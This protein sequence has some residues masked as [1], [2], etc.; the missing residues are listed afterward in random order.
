MAHIDFPPHTATSARAPA[1]GDIR[2][3]P[4]RT[5]RSMDAKRCEKCFWPPSSGAWDEAVPV[6]AG[7]G[8][9]Q[10]R[11]RLSTWPEAIARDIS[12]VRRDRS[13]RP[14]S[15]HLR[16]HGHISPAQT[17][18]LGGRARGGGGG[19]AFPFPSTYMATCAFR[20]WTDRG[21]TCTENRR[22]LDILIRSHLVSGAGHGIGRRDRQNW[23]PRVRRRRAEINEIPAGAPPC[24]AEAAQEPTSSR[25]HRQVRSVEAAVAEAAATLGPIFPS[26]QQCRF[27]DAGSLATISLEAWHQ[28]V[29]ITSTALPLYPRHLR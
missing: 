25:R 22:C 29:D 21:K 24:C 26:G 4:F 20:P 6:Q 1:S 3:R 14:A 10:R 18:L 15:V 11:S 8:R 13:G 17:R 2:P 23:L 28:E 5:R 9:R 19:R 12:A 7:R 27:T 16:R